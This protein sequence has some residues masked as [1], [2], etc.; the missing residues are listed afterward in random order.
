MMNARSIGVVA[1]SLCAGL[2]VSTAN[3][4]I[5]QRIHGD[6][7][8]EIAYSIGNTV[9]GGYVTTGLRDYSPAGAAAEDVL[10]TK[11][12]P[13]GSIEW[14]RAYRGPGRD[15]GY[16]VQQLSDGGYIV[17]AESTSGPGGL[18]ILLMRLD[19]GGGW[20][21][22]GH[23]GGSFMSDPIH[24]P[25]PGVA[26]D[27]GFD[28]VFYVTGNFGG[29]PV[30]LAVGPGGGLI[31]EAAYTDPAGP[32][33]GATYAFTDVKFDEIDGTVVVSGTSIRPDF[34]IP[35]GPAIGVQDAFMMRIRPD[36]TPVWSWNYDFPADLDPDNE[37]I[38]NVRETGDGLDVGPNG[39][40]ILN[41]RT[42]FG[43]PIDPIG[44]HLVSTDRA[45]MPVWSAEYTYSSAD[46][47]LIRPETAY[48]AVRYGPDLSIV[49]TGRVPGDAA[50]GGLNAWESLTK[51]DGTPDWFWR[52]GAQNFTRGESVV[53]VRDDCGFAMAG[54]FNHAG[55]PVSPFARGET[56]L[57]KNNDLGETGCLERRGQFQP[58]FQAEIKEA[59]IR[60]NY[61]QE[62]TQ[63]PNLLDFVDSPELVLCYDDDCT[64]GEPPCPCDINGDGIL[65]LA[66]IGAFI[67][68]FTGSLPCGDLNSDGVWDLADIGLFI[69]CFNAGC[70]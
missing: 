69:S 54:Q 11:Y 48:A 10:I 39:D 64:P 45:G 26:V 35:G 24:F 4:D 43:G 9:D 2:T 67:G 40:I 52:Y 63:A 19:A 58:E 42:D 6:E 30:V 49:Q 59:P 20:L 68:C 36:G 13:D 7:S 47:N 32:D 50:A 8:R 44:T 37:P 56:Y 31:W 3:A 46:G 16:S 33:G 65:D 60:P 23:Y 25:D 51:F 5:F 28:D 34:G 38:P 14:Q 70:P 15:I 57:V 12:F 29:T 22:G 41:G 27:V 61:L 55:D 17:A 21:W 18:G 66:D 62:F 1:L 53:P